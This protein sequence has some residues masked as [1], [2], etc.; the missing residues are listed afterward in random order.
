MAGMAVAM[1]QHEYQ[2]LHEVLGV[3]TVEE[4]A[5]L[6]AETVF[7]RQYRSDQAS[8]LRRYTRPQTILASILGTVISGDTLAIVVIAPP[9]RPEFDSLSAVFGVGRPPFPDRPDVMTLRR[10]EGEWRS[11]LDQPAPYRR[12]SATIVSDST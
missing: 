6:P 7:A 12:G 5:S 9:S 10:W 2:Q 4:L 3:G 11:M 8:R 1:R